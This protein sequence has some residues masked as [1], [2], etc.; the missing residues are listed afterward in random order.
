M[1]NLQDNADYSGNE[2]RISQYYA[3]RPE[4]SY[5]VVDKQRGRMN[6]YKGNKLLNTFSVG[7]GEN[8]GDAQTVTRIENGKVDWTGGNKSTGAGIGYGTGAGSVVTQ[9]T[10]RTTG[11]T[12]NAPCGRI[13]LTSDTTTNG[14]VFSFTVTN[15]FV[16]GSD[17]VQVSV[18]SG[19]GIYY[20][21]VTATATGSFQ[22]S[23]CT[24]VA[25]VSAEAPQLN[26]VVI[27]SVVA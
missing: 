2:Q 14:Q 13:I 26:F 25:V 8:P 21:S 5:V 22:I 20:P 16:A 23:V 10:S 18:K 6:V 3:N 11:V 19:T 4:E 17:V 1:N 27:K 7:T 12:L 9:T 15:S 24:Y